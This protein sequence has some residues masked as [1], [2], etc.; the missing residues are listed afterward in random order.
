MKN[1]W[2]SVFQGNSH[3]FQGLTPLETAD[4]ASSNL[5]VWLPRDL[6]FL[7]YNFLYHRP[8]QLLSHNEQYWCSVVLSLWAELSEG[9]VLLRA[10]WLIISAVNC[11]NGILSFNRCLVS[12]VGRA[13]VCWVGWEVVS[14]NPGQTIN[15]GLLKKKTGEIML[16]VKLLSQ[17]RWLRHWS[18]TLSH[19]P[20]LLHPCTSVGR[21]RKRTCDIIRK[22]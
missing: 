15:Q 10:A 20:Y 18:L 1:C 5:K 6:S 2:K 3:P 4:L 8:Y 21:G 14:S 22:K 16:A 12:S 11:V 19:W 9:I 13:L 17:F 7:L